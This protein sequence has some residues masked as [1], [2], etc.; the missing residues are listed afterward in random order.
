[1]ANVPGV[2]YKS[3]QAFFHDFVEKRQSL[4][5]RG[6]TGAF[7]CGVRRNIVVDTSLIRSVIC[8]LSVF[9]YIPIHIYTAVPDLEGNHFQRR[10]LA[11]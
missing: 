1:M 4:R 9:Y 11:P 8:R 3:L 5:L 2:S 10:A 7:I 6:R